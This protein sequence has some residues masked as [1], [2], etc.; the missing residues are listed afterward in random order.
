MIEYENLHK[1]N[2]PFVDE[3]RR[4]FDE[5]FGSGRFILGTQVEKF[6]EAFAEYCG[7]K[8]AVGV[9]TGLDA[10]TISLRCYDFKPGDE[11][12]VPSNTYIATI[13][14][15][16]H[17]GLK[18]V[19][20]EPDL[21][22]YNLDPSLLDNSL[23]N[24]TVAIMVVH[25]YGKCAAMDQIVDFSR[26]HNLKLIEDCAQAH[27]ATFRTK[28]AGTFGDMG[29]FSFY[30]TKNLGALGDGGC[31]VT[32]GESLS[33]KAS[34]LRNYGSGKKYFN[35]LIGVNS[36]LDEMQ[37]AF[38]NVKLKS[39]DRINAHKQKLAVIYDKGLKE[40]FIRPVIHPDYGDVFHIYNIRHPRRDKLREFLEK[41]GVKTEIHYPVPPHRQKALESFFAGM[42]FPI[43]DEIHATTLSL[44]VSFI[45]TTDD[46]SRVV[47]ILNRF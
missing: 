30:P 27:G 40:D 18:P 8:Y 44:P 41:E 9:G 32:N 38:L 23:T 2:H 12:L 47:E 5:V 43:A 34:I 21:H 3:Y 24:R 39:L 35:D 45:H 19:L 4:A 33:R 36:R 28:K 15:L 17:C 10:L 6:E 29:A 13:F 11:V 22:T 25:L 37:A 31:I 1:L 14:S 46:V 20:V 7:S 16:L 26:R 42:Q